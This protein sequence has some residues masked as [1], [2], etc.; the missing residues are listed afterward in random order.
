MS[1]QPPKAHLEY[2]LLCDDVR[3]ELGNKLSLMGLFRNVYFYALPSSLLKF[4]LIN[5][6]TGE[7]E[8][9][10]E[11]KILSPDRSKVVA[12]AQAAPF[13]IE[14]NGFADNITIFA[15]V[16]FETVGEYPLQVYL[17]GVMVKETNL[18][19]TLISP[20]APESKTIQ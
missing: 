13:R 20:P 6:W 11:V 9:S 8:Y 5:H 2:S 12:Q 7:G 14:P 16:T 4:A 17:N 1:S 10:S 19:V 3:V 15:N 18:A